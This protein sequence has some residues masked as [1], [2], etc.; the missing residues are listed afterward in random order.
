MKSIKIIKGKIVGEKAL[1]K[2]A[3][4]YNKFVSPFKIFDLSDAFTHAGGV[5]V[6]NIL[7][8]INLSDCLNSVVMRRA[9]NRRR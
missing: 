1:K 3:A 9:K 4:K 7:D 5:H 6:A 8:K 2:F